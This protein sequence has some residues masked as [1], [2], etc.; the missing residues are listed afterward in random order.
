MKRTT[1]VLHQLQGQLRVR[2][3]HKATHTTLPAQPEAKQQSQQLRFENLRN[4]NISNKTKTPNAGL[5]P[6]NA[7]STRRTRVAQRRTINIKRHKPSRRA[8]PANP[9]GLRSS[10]C[11]RAQNPQRLR[12]LLQNY[13]PRKTIITKN[14]TTST[15]PNNPSMSDQGSHRSSRDGQKPVSKGLCR[16]ERRSQGHG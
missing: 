11:T 3:H 9:L 6:D 13:L 14:V 2:P 15:T 8:L 16:E 12:T 7:T 10:H 1:P 4:A 5:I